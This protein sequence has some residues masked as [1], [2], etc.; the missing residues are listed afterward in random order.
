[1]PLLPLP[2]STPRNARAT[3]GVLFV[4]AGVCAQESFV[5]PSDTILH[6]TW[7]TQGAS[8]EVRHEFLRTLFRP[9]FAWQ[10]SVGG[11]LVEVLDT[12]RIVRNPA[13]TRLDGQ[14][15]LHVSV[16]KPFLSGTGVFS[17]QQLAQFEGQLSDSAAL[18]GSHTRGRILAGWDKPWSAFRMG[19][20]FGL[21]WERDDP[22]S[23]SL[24][25][26]PGH[27]AH[28]GV[29]ATALGSLEAGWSL[30]EEDLPR[31]FAAHVQRDQGD[32]ELREES[33]NLRARWATRE[34]NLGRILAEGALDASRRRSELL[35]MDRDVVRR[36]ASLT[37]LG[38]AF[39][40]ELSF[41]PRVADTAV[42]DYTGRIPGEDS[43]GWGLGTDLSGA[44]PFGFEHRQVLDWNR[45]DRSV[46]D[47]DGNR[48]DLEKSQSSMNHT[49]ALS[50]TLGWSTADLGGLA[51]R[52]GWLRSL[53]RSRHPENPEPGVSDRPDQDLSETGVG[54]SIRDSL[55]ARG[56][57]PL[58]SWSWIGRDEV[59]LRSVH[60]AETRRLEGHRVSTD[61]AVRPARR[62][63]FE[64]GGKAREQRT[65]YRFDSTRDAGLM[66]VQWD[67]ALQEGPGE[68]PNLR[69]WFEQR[70]TWI[71]ALEGEDFA[72]ENR[73]LLWK[74]GARAWY[75]PSKVWSLSPWLERWV[76]SSRTW[77]GS[78]LAAEPEHSEWR[79][80][81][82]VDAV[83]GEAGEASATIQRI[84]ADPGT[85]DW[86]ISG[87]GRWTW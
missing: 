2:I 41:S 28:Q 16:S 51:L 7:E 62:I 64:W 49:L 87:Q 5:L 46:V 68:R 37:W 30:S 71:G 23:G 54:A 8:F 63:V 59:Y 74:P 32:A 17:V 84:L 27:P 3:V 42:L 20:W 26:D 1:M 57:E 66:E 13:P 70:W 45:S 39:E 48:G 85:D 65:T 34:G 11:S 81:F 77:D 18:A 50:D 73:A 83:F 86:R 60:S 12:S 14:H 29:T 6:P 72:V 36:E 31:E 55:F 35:G 4:A 22:A 80:A 67:A 19:G 24:S 15:G 58:L 56:A 53:G 44:L 76:E 25:L 9:G 47:A 33:A 10:D 21:L 40:Q 82:D 78:R 38:N 75:R 52:A 69:F 79:L 43:R 61:F